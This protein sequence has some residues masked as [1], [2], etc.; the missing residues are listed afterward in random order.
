[1]FC[2][3]QLL[4]R[5][6]SFDLVSSV[7]PHRV[8][9][10]FKVLMLSVIDIGSV[11]VQVVD[12]S[13]TECAPLVIEP[14]TVQTVADISS[15]QQWKCLSTSAY[16]LCTFACF[17]IVAPDL[18]SER[19]NCR[20]TILPLTREQQ[21]QPVLTC[22]VSFF[23]C[24]SFSCIYASVRVWLRVCGVCLL[25]KKKHERKKYLGCLSW[26]DRSQSLLRSFVLNVVSIGAFRITV[27]STVV[28]LQHWR[29]IYFH[30]LR[31]LY[32][33]LSKKLE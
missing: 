6:L 24:F 10:V 32:F 23:S 31:S 30:F 1:M 20:S 5:S 22:S 19:G 28:F 14:M 8:W 11:K 29:P 9:Q 26:T 13:S 33:V 7:K 25:I 3:P 18:F 16:S 27:N 4:A 21:L 15:S 17:F 12:T 2:K